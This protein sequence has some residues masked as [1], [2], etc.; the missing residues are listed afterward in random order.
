MIE[1]IET[2]LTKIKE[3]ELARPM[4]VVTDRLEACRRETERMNRKSAA[5]E[6]VR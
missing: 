4:G 2:E 5:R 6:A 1:K 3:Q